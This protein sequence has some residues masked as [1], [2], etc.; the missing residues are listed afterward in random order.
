MVLKDIEAIAIGSRVALRSKALQL[1]AS[2]VT[3]D[4]GSI[5]GCITTGRDWESHRTAQRRPGLAGGVG[6][7]FK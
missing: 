4:P 5:P 3:T 7:H 2:G 6:R 1:S